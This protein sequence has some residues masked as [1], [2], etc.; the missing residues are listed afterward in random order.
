MSGCGLRDLFH[1]VAL[2]FWESRS[3]VCVAGLESR[4]YSKA[5]VLLWGWLPPPVWGGSETIRRC[6][7]LLG[8]RQWLRTT[9][10]GRTYSPLLTFRPETREL[11]DTTVL[12]MRVQKE[13]KEKKKHKVTTL[14]CVWEVER[15]SRRCVHKRYFIPN[16]DHHHHIW[17]RKFGIVDFSHNITWI[18]YT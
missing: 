17:C 12:R 13:K 11:G 18:L 7:G 8:R 4:R 16:R 14:L 15:C 5:A 1:D 3:H 10:S 9:C 2:V 6:W